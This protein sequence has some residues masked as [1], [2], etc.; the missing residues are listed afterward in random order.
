[1]PRQVEQKGV[2]HVD[3]DFNLRIDASI[4]VLRTHRTTVA[5]QKFN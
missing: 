5:V 1:M 2:N 4:G 3:P